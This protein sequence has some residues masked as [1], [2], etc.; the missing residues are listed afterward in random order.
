VSRDDAW[1]RAPK[2]S[3]AHRSLSAPAMAWAGAS[4]LGDYGAHTFVLS[5]VFPRSAHFQTGIA[6]LSS[7]LPRLSLYRTKL[8]LYRVHGKINAVNIH[9][10]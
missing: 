3:I 1:Q 2:A 6:S 7:C 9:V 4:T 10:I 8:D 5:H